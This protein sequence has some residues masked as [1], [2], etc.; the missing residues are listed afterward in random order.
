MGY[1]QHRLCICVVVEGFDMSGYIP[2]H[3]KN[4]KNTGSLVIVAYV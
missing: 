4:K 3:L 2:K 1:F